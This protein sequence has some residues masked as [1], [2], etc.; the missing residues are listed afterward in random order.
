V[1]NRLHKSLQFLVLLAFSSTL[2]LAADHMAIACV[3]GTVYP[4]PTTPAI[5]N[6]VLLIEDGNIVTVATQSQSKYDIP[7][8][9]QRLDCKG[10]VI[11][12]GFLEQPRALR[13]WMAGCGESSRIEA[14][15][16]HAGDA[17]PLG[18]HDGV[19][20]RLGS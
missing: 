3:G 17:H 5:E 14:R 11:V 12:A 1:I 18:R 4:S 10:K 2:A 13:N 7:Q 8:L 15:R 16:S 6:A 9:V 19:G 20:L